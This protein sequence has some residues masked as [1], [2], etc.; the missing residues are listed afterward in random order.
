MLGARGSLIPGRIL[1]AFLTVPSDLV[2]VCRPHAWSELTQ[3]P[4]SGMRSTRDIFAHLIEAEAYLL[5]HVVRGLP[6]PA[7]NA[8]AWVSLDDLL[9]VWAP[10]RRETVRWLGTVA[11]DDVR[12]TREFLWVAS[13]IA[14]VGELVWQVVTHEQYHRGQIYTR[15]ALL[16]RRDLPVRDLLR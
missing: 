12:S 11:D 5:G 10:Q 14:S 9:S 4:G 6:M 15:L 2:A 7:V 3:S 1:E 13:G 16:G 8:G